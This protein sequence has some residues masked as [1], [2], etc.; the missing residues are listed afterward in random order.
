[1][2]LSTPEEMRRAGQP[3][4]HCMDCHVQ[5]HSITGRAISGNLDISEAPHNGKN[6]M[7]YT[8]ASTAWTPWLS[9]GTFQNERESEKNYSCHH[10]AWNSC[11]HD[12]YVFYKRCIYTYIYV[13]LMCPQSTPSKNGWLL[14]SSTPLLPILFSE[15]VQNLKRWGGKKSREHYNKCWQVQNKIKVSWYQGVLAHC[16]KLLHLLVNIKAAHCP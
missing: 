5:K 12:F 15:S 13:Y 11:R 16:L 10:S 4:S 14:I 7:R 2:K 9:V 6:L 1:M 8:N 3:H